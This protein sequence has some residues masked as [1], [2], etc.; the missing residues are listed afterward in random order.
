MSDPIICFG[1]Q[2]CG[3]FPKRFL[4]AKIQTAYRLQ[5]EIGGKI[6]FF[7]HDSDHDYRETI[8]LLKEKGTDKEERLNFE[9]EN[10]VQ[11]K[12][13]P[14]YLK[15][16]PADWQAPMARR[17]PRFVEPELVDI[18]KSVQ[19]NIVAD[20]CLDMYKKMGLLDTIEIVRS[21]DPK[22]REETCDVSEYYVDIP[23]EGEIARA[24]FMKEKN[25]FEIHRG[26]EEYLGIPYQ[27]FT[28]AQI[29]P[30]RETRFDWMQ[31]VIHC[32]HYIAGAGEKAYLG[33]TA[34]KW[35][36]VTFVPRD[37]ID[38]PHG[39]WIKTGFEN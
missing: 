14:L 8:T 37:P 10:K 12:Y 16:I 1:Q 27:P 35:P 30:T 39:A 24:K 21:G 23:Y 6:V 7:Y 9:Q 15:R 19:E 3:I 29:N 18:F 31:S 13:S 26:G 11:K 2:P 32:T 4:V 33:D 22:F 20:F 34:S 17:L 38:D 5:Q 28:K 25:V 36:D